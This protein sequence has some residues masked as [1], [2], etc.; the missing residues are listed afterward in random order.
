M[1]EAAILI[2]LQVIREKRQWLAQY[3]VEEILYLMERQE[4]RSD[5]TGWGFVFY[6][7]YIVHFCHSDIEID[8]ELVLPVMQTCRFCHTMVPAIYC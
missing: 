8:I 4:S 5:S 3:Y 6:T 7:A 2:E 1:L